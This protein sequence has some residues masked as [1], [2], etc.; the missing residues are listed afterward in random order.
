MLESELRHG[1]G[2]V[3]TTDDGSSSGAGGAFKI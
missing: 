3:Q 1:V 2:H